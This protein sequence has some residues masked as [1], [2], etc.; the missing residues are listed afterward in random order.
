MMTRITESLL[1]RKVKSIYDM[2]AKS[3]INKKER[4]NLVQRLE[5]NINA[6]GV[7][8]GHF[9]FLFEAGKNKLEQVSLNKTSAQLISAP[10]AFFKDESYPHLL[11]GVSQDIVLPKPLPPGLQ[12]ALQL[13][14]PR[15]TEFECESLLWEHHF[16]MHEINRMQP[17]PVL[18]NPEKNGSLNPSDYVFG[19]TDEKIESYTKSADIF[20]GLMCY[21]YG[22]DALTPY[23]TKC[24]DIVP[25]FLQSLPFKSMM[26]MSTEGGERMHYMHQQRFFQHSSRGGGWVYQDPLLNVFN[27]MYRQIRER[28]NATDKENQ[29]QFAAFVE[30]C[31]QGRQDNGLV[32]ATLTSVAVDQSFPL[33][34]KRFAL[35]GSF[36]SVK[37]TQEKLKDIITDKGMCICAH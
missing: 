3:M 26:R 13:S 6:R 21:R 27:H 12:Q 5:S 4:D 11:E 8:G 29:E 31:L 16:N 1:T 23:M 33:H 17:T 2:E 22:S 9:K 7:R 36:G 32:S 30:D 10:P 20:H 28:V 14:S 25:I 18:V 35:V 34:G 24:I 37:L 19:V 15:I